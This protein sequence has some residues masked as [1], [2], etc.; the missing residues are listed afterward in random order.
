MGV[1]PQSLVVVLAAL[2]AGAYS[3]HEAAEL[4]HHRRSSRLALSLWARRTAVRGLAVWLVAQG[5]VV[6]ASC[7]GGVVW[8]DLDH[9]LMRA[10]HVPVVA[11]LSWGRAWLS[12]GLGA[13]LMTFVFPPVVAWAV[14][15]VLTVAPL[16]GWWVTANL[17]PLQPGR[18]EWLWRPAVGVGLL[19]LATAVGALRRPGWSGRV[20]RGLPRAAAV[21][22]V[23]LVVA[24]RLAPRLCGGSLLL[25]AVAMLALSCSWLLLRGG[26]Q[27]NPL[28]LCE[29][30]LVGQRA[31]WLCAAALMVLWHGTITLGGW[32]LVLAAGERDLDLTAVRPELLTG[33]AAPTAADWQRTA[34]YLTYLAE[35]YGNY[36]WCGRHLLLA[37][38]IETARL[39]QFTRGRLT[40]G[41]AVERFGAVR[42]VAPPNWPALRTVGEVG[43]AM[44]DEW[45]PL[46][47]PGSRPG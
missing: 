13:A 41:D 9:F 7:T 37:S 44:L 10:E 17:M 22:L 14:G 5:L 35:R 3:L 29:H 23:A 11:T 30:L 27:A 21:T 8:H 42:A 2:V 24:A 31:A 45:G 26:R 43:R 4:A 25:P 1:P 20:P 40:L 39:G 19:G 15:L 36:P 32:S 46:V 12:L 34:D 16:Y 28:V 33:T 47:D 18:S 38:W 6:L